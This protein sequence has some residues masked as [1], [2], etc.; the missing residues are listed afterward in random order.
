[1]RF[2]AFNAR[3]RLLAPFSKLRRTEERLT[4]DC[5]LIL[6]C[7]EEE[8]MK[9]PLLTQSEVSTSWVIGKRHIFLSEGKYMAIIKKWQIHCQSHLFIKNWQQTPTPRGREKAKR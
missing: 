7:V 4:E 2:K 3:Y 6:Q 8:H 5:L 1:M 9:S